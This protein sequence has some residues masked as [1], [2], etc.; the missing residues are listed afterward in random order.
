MNIRKLISDNLPVILTSVAVT[1]V[2]STAV[3]AV[4]ATP[5]AFIQIGY[6]EAEFGRPLTPFEKARLVWK[7]YVPAALVGAATISAIIGVQSTHSKR[8][9]ALVGLYSILEKNS[10]DF[11]A[12]AIDAIGEKKVKDIHDQVAQQHLD[13][14]PVKDTQVIVTGTGEHLCYDD[15]SGRY[16]KSSHNAIQKAVNEVNAEAINNSYA[17]LNDFYRRIGLNVLPTGEEVGWRPDK[18]LE[19]NLTS[20]LTE[21]NEPCL[22]VQ[23]TPAP[24]RGYWRGHD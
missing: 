22:V 16:F 13:E 8:Q 24:I 15:H 2:A 7:D 11:K 20:G 9:A 23:F 12:K 4:K 10:E 18:I 1:G 3:L 14:N 19:I 5:Q 21:E 6:A 17:S